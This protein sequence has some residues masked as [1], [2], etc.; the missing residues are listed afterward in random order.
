MGYTLIDETITL[1]ITENP[2][3]P[4]NITVWESYDEFVGIPHIERVGYW[5]NGTDMGMSAWYV[6]TP[7]LLPVGNWTLIASLLTDYIAYFS[8]DY[9]TQIIND[10][11][12]IGFRYSAAITDYNEIREAWWSKADGML[13]HY[14]WYHYD[15]RFEG[16]ETESDIVADAVQ[17]PVPWSTIM[18]IGGAAGV[19]VIV[20]A[21]VFLRRKS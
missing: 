9:T 5:E 6:I 11:Q 18:L 12:R 2:V 8:V 7:V 19:V 4:D 15:F 10:A 20:G 17:S 21:A 1:E 3:L 16:M 13:I 14:R